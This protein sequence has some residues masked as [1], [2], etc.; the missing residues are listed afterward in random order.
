MLCRAVL[1]CLRSLVVAD[2]Q[3]VAKFDVAWKNNFIQRV[4]G[5]AFD[6]RKVCVC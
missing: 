3:V 5:A 2:W 1:T 6:E 4:I